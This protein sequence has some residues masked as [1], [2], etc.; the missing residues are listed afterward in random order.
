MEVGQD[1]HS[2]ETD[3]DNL[4]LTNFDIVTRSDAKYTR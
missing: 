1:S 3:R 2:L 4:N